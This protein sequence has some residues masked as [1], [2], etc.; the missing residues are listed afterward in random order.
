MDFIVRGVL[1]VYD[2]NLVESLLKRENSFIYR[3]SVQNH[4]KLERFWKAL[5]V[6]RTIRLRLVAAYSFDLR[7]S[8]EG[9][10]HYHFPEEHRDWYPNPHVQNY[11][12][13]GDHGNAMQQMLLA[14]DYIG[15]LEQAVCSVVNLNMHDGTVMGRFVEEL[16][17]SWYKKGNII[18]L[19]D[20]TATTVEGAFKWL[21]EHDHGKTEEKED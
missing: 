5:L 17:G 3:T 9:R 18:E 12:C 8:A 4:A 14:N 16:F 21:E 15:A 20:G 11:T 13:I 6:D 2:T 1:S 7:G 10:S 19:P